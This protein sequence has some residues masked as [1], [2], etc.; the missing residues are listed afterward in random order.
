M[1]LILRISS[2][3]YLPRKMLVLLIIELFLV[4]IDFKSMKFVNTNYDI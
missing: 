3:Q 4:A 2:D 1:N